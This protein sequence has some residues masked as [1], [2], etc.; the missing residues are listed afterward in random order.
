MGSSDV[1]E[2]AERS[3]PGRVIRRFIRADGMSHSRALAYETMLIVF[4]GFIGLLGIAALTDL[5]Q[6]RNT[7]T[8]LGRSLAPGP[9]GELLRDAAASGARH[10]T[11][12]AVVGLAG[13]ALAGTIAM[14]ELERTGNRIAGM[15]RDRR[16]VS[17][18]VMAFVLAITVGLVFVAG[19]MALGAGRAIPTGFAWSD[20]FRGVWSVVRWPVGVVMIALAILLLFRFGPKATLGPWRSL[21]AGTVVALV[22][23]VAF[24]GLLSLYFSLASDSS[25]YGPL[26]AIIALMLWSILGS[27]AL[28]IGM[29]TAAELSD[30]RRPHEEEEAVTLPEPPEEEPAPAL[31][32]NPRTYGS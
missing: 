22:L 5:E 7:V 14:A 10:A 1:G 31:T 9:S 6:V 3:L 17:R 16:L 2:K 30:A 27:L 21:I 8:E 18:Y 25:P 13:A 28:A 29:A 32:G 11:T 19:G 4:S 20:Q 15:R 12:A 26:L 24:T 23:W